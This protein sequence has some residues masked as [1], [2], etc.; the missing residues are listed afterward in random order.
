[1]SKEKTIKCFG[2]PVY[3]YREKNGLQ[4]KYALGIRYHTKKTASVNIS[5]LT[6]TS[7]KKKESSDEKWYK[8][9]DAQKKD[10]TAQYKQQALNALPI[11]P[12]D[13]LAHVCIKID[14]ALKQNPT[15]ERLGLVFFMGIGDYFYATNFIELLHKKYQKLPIDAYVSNK[16]DKNNSPLVAQLLKNNPNIER[17]FLFNGKA[18]DKNWKKYDYSAVIKKASKKTL[19]LPLIYEFKENITSRTLTLCQTFSL[20]IPPIICPPIIYPAVSLSDNVY[21]LYKT[22]KSYHL[23][24][25]KKIVY[26]QLTGRSLAFSY[27]QKDALIQKLLNNGFIVITAEESSVNH[28]ALFMIDTRYMIINDTIELIRLLK[29]DNLPIYLLGIPSCFTAI[30]SGLHLPALIM[31]CCFDKQIESVYFPN[32]FIISPVSYSCLPTG[33]IFI[34]PPGTFKEFRNQNGLL[35]R[36]YNSDY[37]FDRFTDMLNILSDPCFRETQ[38]HR[39]IVINQSI[40]DKKWF[41]SNSERKQVLIIKTDHIGDHLLFRNFIAELK[42]SEKYKNAVVHFIGNEVCREVSELLDCKIIDKSFWVKHKLPSYST[43]YTDT[44]RERLFK[45]GLLKQYDLIFFAGFNRS[46]NEKCNL[47]LIKGIAY[48]ELICHD[49]DVMSRQSDSTQFNGIYTR[50]IHIPHV[51]EKF[52]FE[53]NKKLFEEITEEKISLKEPFLESSF[54]RSL[55]KKKKKYIVI[56][57]CSRNM[58]NRWHPLNYF[59]LVKWLAKTYQLPIYVIGSKNDEVVYNEYA[60]LF[61]KYVVPCFGESWKKIFQLLNSAVLYIGPDSGCYHI[62]TLLNRKTVVISRGTALYRFNKYSSRANLITV[63]PEGLE[64]EI[65]E[66]QKLNETYIKVIYTSTNLVSVKSVKNAII[67]IMEK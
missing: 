11:M 64:N 53:I 23:A 40:P 3:K 49:G 67:K 35:L 5:S 46:Y 45:E 13:H 18:N 6:E 59:E 19:I 22:V 1:M 24:T 60:D 62:S 21:I 33:R 66:Q 16:T 29:S 65:N 2:I 28:P 7:V 57:L 38:S 50:I 41:L 43:D 15:I 8:I 9:V 20:P 37:V 48:K 56:T 47:R 25:Q 58:E 54:I 26:L 42:K 31:Q 14:L 17:I 12:D 10:I 51:Y 44:A 34:A 63:L 39:E 61:D 55:G 27:S 52:E 36:E 4:E 30:S 32:E